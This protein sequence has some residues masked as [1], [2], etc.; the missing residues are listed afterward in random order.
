MKSTHCF[1]RGPEFNSQ[2]LD[3]GSQ[4]SVTPVSGD[5][6]PLQASIGTRF[7]HGAKTCIQAKTSIYIK[8]NLTTMFWLNISI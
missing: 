4:P 6:T 8:I 1:S 5:L 2:Q 3:G 7:V